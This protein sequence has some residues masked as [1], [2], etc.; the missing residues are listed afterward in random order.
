MTPIEMPA[1]FDESD[2]EFFDSHLQ[3]VAQRFARTVGDDPR[4]EPLSMQFLIE[5][6]AMMLLLESTNE[7]TLIDLL[8]LVGQQS[9]ARLIAEINRDVSTGTVDW[10]QVGRALGVTPDRARQMFTDHSAD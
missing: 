4:R 6:L 2:R 7:V 10:D 8:S 3:A 1:R 5:R 9:G